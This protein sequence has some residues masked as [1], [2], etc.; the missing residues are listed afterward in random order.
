M[1][2]ALLYAAPPVLLWAAVLGKWPAVRRRPDAPAGRAWWLALLALAVALTVL[3]PP[4]QQAVDRTAG[5]VNLALLVGHGLALGCACGAQAFLLYSSYP[6]AAASPK[7]GRQVWVLVGTLLA[8]AVLFTVGQAQHE[9]FDLL[10]R[11][12]TAW[13]V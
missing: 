6:P 13:P 2:R 5:M 1:G 7:V 9:T 3:A 10:S 8:M 12:L 4:V 11:D